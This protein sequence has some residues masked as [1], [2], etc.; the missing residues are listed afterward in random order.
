MLWLVLVLVQVACIRDDAHLNREHHSKLLS[1]ESSPTHNTAAH[2]WPQYTRHTL[3]TDDLCLPSRGAGRAQAA[4]RQS[5]GVYL[6]RQ[7]TAP[8]HVWHLHAIRQRLHCTPSALVIKKYD[9]YSAMIRFACHS[10]LVQDAPELLP[11]GFYLDRE[12]Q[13]KH[14]SMA[15]THYGPAEADVLAGKLV[16]LAQGLLG[17]ERF[18]EGTCTAGA[19]PTQCAS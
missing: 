14:L 1:M 7:V 15:S 13:V 5:L 9:T 6:D 4:A 3:M 2:I 16:L 11:G 17:E 19:A 10:L 8:V 18:N 12:P